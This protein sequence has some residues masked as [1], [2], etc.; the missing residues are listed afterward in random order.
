MIL[1][2]WLALDVQVSS[3]VFDVLLLTLYVHCAVLLKDLK[4]VEGVQSGCILDVAGADI[5]A[6]CMWTQYSTLQEQV[7]CAGDHTSVPGTCQSAITGQDALDERGAI[8]GAIG[9]QSMDLI[10][11]FAHDDF[12]VLDALDFGFLLL[13]VLETEA[14]QALELEFLGHGAGR[15]GKLSMMGWREMGP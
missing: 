9:V 10:S 15:S 2:R 7:L 5:E 11:D 3:T 8:M 1:S 4:L 13:S 14:R 6:C 12:S